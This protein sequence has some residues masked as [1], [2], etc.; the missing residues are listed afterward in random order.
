MH[1]H[2][3][4]RNWLEAVDIARIRGGF[5]AIAP[6]ADAFTVDFYA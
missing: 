3:E 1:S 2:G 5:A 6:Q 4:T